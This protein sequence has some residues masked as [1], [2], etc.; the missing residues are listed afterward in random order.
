MSKSVANWKPNV[1][2]SCI[3]CGEYGKTQMIHDYYGTEGH[4]RH[5]CMKHY[6]AQRLKC[7]ICGEK[8]NF[9]TGCHLWIA[10]E[11]LVCRK[12]LD[13]IIYR[14]TAPIELPNIRKNGTLLTGLKQFK[15]QLKQI[16]G[17][18]SAIISRK[19]PNKL[20][21][22]CTKLLWTVV[23]AKENLR[24]HLVRNTNNIYI[25]YMFD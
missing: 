15:N 23:D 14:R 6:N 11:K 25:E 3:V 1:M 21:D 2:G 10:E 20:E 4:D 8:S 9:R 16:D 24:K 19:T 17:Y 22:D 13:E 12:H 7:E 5:Y 18:V